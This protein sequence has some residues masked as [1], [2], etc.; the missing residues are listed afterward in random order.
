MRN[1]KRSFSL[2]VTAA[3]L[4]W[5]PAPAQ[6][7][8]VPDGFR[9]EHRRS[10]APG[11]EHL[12]LL[13]SEPRLVVHVAS[14]SKSAPVSLR[15][16]LSNELVA[17]P[18][19]RMERTSSMCVRVACLVA[20]NG[21]FYFPETGEP[22]GAVVSA[23]IPARSPSEFHHQLMIG[24]DR[25]L[26]A[27]P[28]SLRGL[29]A[30]SDLKQVAVDGL[31]VERKE[32]LLVLYTSQFA[33]STG[34]NRFGLEI[35]GVV[36]RPPGPLRLGQTA[37][38][39]LEEMRAE[40][41]SPIQ[42]GDR[43]GIVLSGHGRGA[44]ALEDLWDR[45][46][47]GEAG[48]DVLIRIESAPKVAEAIGGTPILV[49][50]GKRWF[51]DAASTFVRGRHPR[52]VVGWNDAET[53]LVTIDGRQ[54]GYSVGMTLAETAA[55]MI[56]LGA[57]EAINLDGGGSTT[58][59]RSGEV[60]NRPSDRAVRSSGG[61]SIVHAPGRGQQV[62]GNVERPVAV[63]LALLPADE[64]LDAVAAGALREMSLP[65]ALALPAPHA[66]P[67]SNPNGALPALLPY[68]QTGGRSVT[69]LAVLLNLVVAAGLFLALRTTR[70]V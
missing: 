19:P 30:S 42:G 43:R 47:S 39:H 59:V 3:L 58:F 52:T 40:G 62:V 64:N 18:E 24:D 26:S 66:D 61:D 38:V 69:A 53:Y 67:G 45:I 8:S 2:L 11:V 27:G 29:I 50:G 55:F 21:D 16:V 34:T 20:V 36:Q 7:V 35:T 14:I 41:N 65:T 37:L 44:E 13:S 57:A 10:I 70:S 28:L 68:E 51:E 32:N 54:P 60:V 15:V 17:G 31:N 25:G 1:V 49:R 4:A 63:A 48:P 9:L 12:T 33:A 5:L 22:L 23:G 6:A 46:Q 56:D